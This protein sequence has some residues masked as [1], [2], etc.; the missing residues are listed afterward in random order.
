M[1]KYS[2]EGNIKICCVSIDDVFELPDPDVT[3]IKD[4]ENNFNSYNE[5]PDPLQH[6]FIICDLRDPHGEG[7]IAN[8]DGMSK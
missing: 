7:H 1:D 8:V 2:D 3:E 5:L 4:I 6:L